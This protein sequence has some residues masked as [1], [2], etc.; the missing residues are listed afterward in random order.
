MPTLANSIAVAYQ[1]NVFA[2]LETTKGTLAFPAAAGTDV[3]VAAGFPDMNQNPAFVQSQEVVY[4][5]DILNMFQNVTP[6][7]TMTLPFYIRPSGSLGVVPMGANLLTSL[8]GKQT[9][10]ASTSVTYAQQVTKPSLSVWFQRG[11]TVFNA[12]GA[13]V[14]S[15][16][17]GYT[18]KGGLLATATLQ[19]LQ[20]GYAGTSQVST[21]AAQA[22]TSVTVD[23]GTK[24]T[25]G[26][27]IWNSTTQAGAGDKA[28]NGYTVSAVVGNV[29][30]IAPGI[31][32]TG[33][34]AIGDT[35]Q[36]YLPTGAPAGT[37]LAMR[38][39]AFTVEGTSRNLKGLDFSYGDSVKVL[40]DEITTSGYP[41]SYIESSRV[42]TGALH[43]YLRRND[44]GLIT[45]G[46]STN[47]GALSIAMGTVA[48]SIATLNM[49][50]VVYEV[51]QLKNNAPAVEFDLKYTAISNSGAGED[52]CTLAFT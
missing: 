23:D 28:T 21:A 10:V 31:V 22:A 48:G 26:S 5:R 52:S 3:V 1:Q 47:K 42:I 6:A 7:G 38:Q 9:I 37:A 35:I 51:P 49:P 15:M 40:D 44:I 39:A 34:W 29:L 25:V 8:F 27:V 43:A 45:S 20:L 41:Q 18:T 36:G 13:V 16:K 24:Y 33:G 14:D 12:A 11:H 30:T 17:I 50:K 4:S 32:G 19:F 46:M 2:T